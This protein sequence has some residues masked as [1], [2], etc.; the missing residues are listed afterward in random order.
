MVDGG[1]SCCWMVFIN[2]QPGGT[3]LQVPSHYQP[4]SSTSGLAFDYCYY[5]LLLLILLD[6]PDK[7][8]ALFVAFPEQPWVLNQ[9]G[10][11]TIVE[12]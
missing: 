10:V 12:V 3:T 8:D 11:Q 1:R 4:Q 7:S 6:N 9:L 2:S 5:P